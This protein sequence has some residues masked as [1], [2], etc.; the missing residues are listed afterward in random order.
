MRLDMGEARTLLPARKFIRLETRELVG[1]LVE[2]V[3][4]DAPEERLRLLRGVNLPKPARELRCS[5]ACRLPRAL[6]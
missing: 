6:I 2:R 4:A 3:G 5:L 1:R